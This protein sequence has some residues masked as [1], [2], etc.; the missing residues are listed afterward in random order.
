MAVEGVGNGSVGV[1]FLVSAGVIYEI[2]AAAC[3]SPQTTEIN[4]KSRS[5]TLM[6]WVYIGLA[7]GVLFVGVAA[8]LDKNKAVPIIGGGALAAGILY[9]SYNHANE[10]G[11]K[12]DLPGTEDGG[13]GASSS[14]I[15]FNIDDVMHGA[16]SL[17][18]AFL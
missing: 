2:V 8:Y 13:P 6:K 17:A 9:W 10:S 11:L 14:S 16:D 18:L 1:A 12:S 5:A 15:S 4:A 3:S 7:Q